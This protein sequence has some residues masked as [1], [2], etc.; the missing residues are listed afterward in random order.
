MEKNNCYINREVSW[1]KFN[2]RVLEEAKDST[3]PLCERLSFLSIFQSNLEEF[4]MVRVGT[5][6]DQMLLKEKVQDN[7]TGMTS[8][9]QIQAIVE[10]T[11][12]LCK[13]RDSVYEEIMEQIYTY[14]L[15]LVKFSDLLKNDVNDIE[16]YFDMEIAPL[17]SPM[18]VGKKQSFPF[19]GNG[20]IYAVVVMETIRGKE[21]IGIIPC[22]GSQLKRLVAIHKKQG[23]YMLI[24][25][26]I[27]HFV[28]KIFYQYNIKGKSLVKITRNA[29][30]NVASIEDEDLNYRDVMVEAIKMRK[31]LAPVRLEL[32]RELDMKV[33]QVLCYNLGLNRSQ[34]F[35]SNVPLN[36]ECV[37]EIRDTLRDRSELFYAKHMPKW[38]SYLVRNSSMMEQ[39]KNKDVLL[40][41]PYD[42]VKPFL[43]MIH[44]AA[45]DDSVVS[46]K[47]T[48]YRLAKQSKVVEALIEAAENGKE[49]VVLVE[50]KARFD[51]ENNIE[52]SRRL[53]NA[54]CQVIYGIDGVKV[55]SKLCL[56]IK[57]Q[58][59]KLEYITQIG[60]GNYN[61]K[62]AELY[63]DLTVITADSI[64]GSE[65]ANI[66]MQ[67][68]LG[69]V[70]SPQKKLLVAPNGLQNK[71]IDM[72]NEQ[73]ELAKAGQEAYIGIKINSLT[74]IKLINKLIE[75]S[76]NG[77]K[78]DMI[79]RGICCL[80]PQV[81]GETENINVISIVGRFLEHSR[82]YIFGNENDKIYIGS[83]DWMTRNTLKRIEVAVPIMNQ[84]LKIKIRKIFIV[85]LTDN[86]KARRMNSNGDYERVEKGEM[87]LNSQEILSLTV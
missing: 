30:I 87:E 23:T 2:K 41:F 44:E 83:A 36:M 15:K 56:I 6:Q 19:M 77:V 3:V 11:T 12:K 66:F 43:Y 82:I 42:S 58:D 62:T 57:K 50:L 39:I 60:T 25:E 51:E 14:G 52:W 34:V 20:L 33:V 40:C 54:G 28:T 5:L 21:K 72:I 78:I 8:S 35:I 10:E 27:L 9:E 86:S 75:A 7:K 74:D 29:D 17:L 31:K 46:I 64:I 37:S 80:I 59:N 26:V 71:L 45:N 81:K 13:E 1:L 18:I 47:M 22:G 32:T 73:I 76:Q 69:E 61:E 53:E 24:E 70:A 63:T 68:G 67:L 4:F 84:E 85:M 79:I 16:N 38:P 55:H 48:L 49:V 65:V